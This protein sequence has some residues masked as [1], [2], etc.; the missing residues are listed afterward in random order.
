MKKFRWQ[1]IIIFLTGVVVGILL[2]L[3]QPKS[4]ADVSEE[5]IQPLQ[6]GVYTEALVGEFQR[7]NPLLDTYNSVD[8]DVDEL[9]FS[10]LIKFDDRGMPVGDL[11]ES[12]GTSKDGSLYTVT[13]REGTYW[14]DGQPLSADDVLFTIEMIRQG[15][16]TI[17]EDLQTFWQGIDVIVLNERNLQFKLPEPFAPFLDYLHVK[18]LPRHLLGGMSFDE[19]ANAN[20]N[21]H[22]IGSGPYKFTKLVVEDAWIKGIELGVNENYYADTAFI[23]R[24]VFLYYPD[25]QSAMAAYKDGLVQG[26]S[27]IPNSILQ[28]ALKDSSMAIYSSRLPQ[29]TTIFLNL[30]QPTAKFLEDVKVRQALMLGLNRKYM[31]DQL[32][33]GQAVITD[34]PILPGTWAYYQ[35]A[36]TISFD[37]DAANLI[38]QQAGYELTERVS[39]T[40]SAQLLRQKDEV[41]LSLTLLH[42][43]E[44][45]YIEMAQIIQS[46][47]SQLGIEVLLE[48][49]PYDQLINERL[50]QR[51]YQAALLTLNLSNSPD[52]DPYPFWNQVQAANGQNYSQWNNKMASEY[53]EK[54]RVTTDI[55]ERERLYHNFQVIF[56]QELPSLVLF[57]PIY[58]YG[59]S[60][61]IQGVR[62]GPLFDT[63]DRYFTLSQWY[64][65][66]TVK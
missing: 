13:L 17:S 56:N 7:L 54:A 45:P 62:V 26:I 38:L 35:V 55:A 4:P 5:S 25:E 58:N 19:M 18:I 53:L 34:S 57:Y 27:R 8:R 59:V 65:M 40:G 44:T 49:V 14:H 32:L 47:W 23:E 21:L 30:D 37:P 46:N 22:P 48:A 64:L 39:D 24:L 31:I 2:L 41:V 12:W 28:D 1:I 15:G 60:K 63:S 66:S 33:M 10:S 52:P 42:P 6:G 3:E 36:K 9:I 50:A 20:Y 51:D 61:D 16:M 11:A 29:F 43:D